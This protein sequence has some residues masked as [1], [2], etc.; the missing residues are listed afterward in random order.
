MGYAWD[1]ILKCSMKCT[2][3]ASPEKIRR[4]L[5]PCF[6]CPPAPKGVVATRGHCI[7]GKTEQDLPLQVVLVQPFFR[8]TLWHPNHS[9]ATNLQMLTSSYSTLGTPE[10][11]R[12]C[13]FFSTHYQGPAEIFALRFVDVHS[14]SCPSGRR[15]GC[16][17]HPQWKA[18]VVAEVPEISQNP[19]KSQSGGDQDCWQ[20]KYHANI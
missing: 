13:L 16:V 20:Y 19:R 1:R 12:R 8:Y 2:H 15:H 11:Q 14:L 18:L 17:Q 7:A 9:K 10:M 5:Q 3:V 4:T 6:F